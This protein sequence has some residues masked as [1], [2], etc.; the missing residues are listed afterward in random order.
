MQQKKGVKLQENA[1]IEQKLHEIL[2][3]MNKLTA[4]FVAETHPFP[5]KVFMNI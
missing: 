1:S 5:R 2:S 3:R 4:Y